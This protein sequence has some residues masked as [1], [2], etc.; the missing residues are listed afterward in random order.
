MM[1]FGC[2]FSTV[3]NFLLIIFNVSKSTFDICATVAVKAPQNMFKFY[4]SKV[5]FQYY[6]SLYTISILSKFK[7]F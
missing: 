7:S 1:V 4:S 2:K 5:Y 6:K 3:P